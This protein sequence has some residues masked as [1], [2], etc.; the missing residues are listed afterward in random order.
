MS[1]RRITAAVVIAASAFG[2]GAA[3]IAAAVPSA[4]AVPVAAARPSDT[5][6]GQ[7]AQPD[8]F[9]WG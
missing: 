8:G 7:H 2:S 5:W 6:T 4:A 9:G 3:V 1:I